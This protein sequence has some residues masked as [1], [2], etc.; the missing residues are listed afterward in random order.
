M[1]T[2]PGVQRRLIVRDTRHDIEIAENTY[3]P[4]A[5]SADRPIHHLGREFGVV[6]SGRM[7]I[8]V[9][10]RTHVLQRGDAISFD[11][12]MPHRF[13]NIGKEVARTIW[14]NVH[15]SRSSRR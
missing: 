12:S 14:V 10:G 2:G 4:G 7:Q 15:S 9:D 3:L 13:A 6:L 5:A 11:S 1:N 8:E